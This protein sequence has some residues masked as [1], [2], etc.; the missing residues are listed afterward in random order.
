MQVRLELMAERKFFVDSHNRRWA[1]AFT[2]CE[3]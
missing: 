2:L 3:H 1:R